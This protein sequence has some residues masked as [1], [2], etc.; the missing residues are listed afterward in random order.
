MDASE[1]TT[2][3]R[4]IASYYDLIVEGPT[5]PAGP[6]GGYTGPTGQKGDQGYPFNV[7]GQGP[8]GTGQSGPVYTRDY[9]DAQPSGFAFLDTTNGVLYVKNTNT[10]GDWSTGIPFGQ[11]ETGPTGRAG[12][13]GAGIAGPTGPTGYVGVDGQT[14]PTGRTGPTGVTGPTGR[15]GVLGPTGPLGT[16]PTGPT[17]PGATGVTGSTGP[18]GQRGFTG[19]TG[20]GSTGPTGPMPNSPPSYNFARLANNAIVT[21]TSPAT[22][23]TLI[24]FTLPSAGTWDVLY[25][26]RAQGASP[27]AG[28]VGLWDSAGNQLLDS[29]ILAS[30]LTSSDGSGAGTGTGRYFITTTDAATYTMRAWASTGSFTVYGTADGNGASSVSWVQLTGGYVG[31][32]GAAGNTGPTGA[33]GTAGAAGTTGATGP[34]GPTGATGSSGSTGSTGTTGSTGSTG[35]TGQT[36][37]TGTTG[38]T[39][40]GNV[41]ASYMRGSRAAGQS[42]SSSPT[43]IIFTQTD[44][45]SGSDISLNQ[46]TGQITL[47]A[48]KT[49]RLIASVPNFVSSGA[50]PR[51][52]FGWYNEISSTQIGS[53][54]TFYSATD[55]A[56]N[57]GSGT[58]AEHI[59][60]PNV[61]TVVSFRYLAGTNISQL[62]GN[63]DF[64]TANSYPWFEIITIA[65]YSPVSAAPVAPMSYVQTTPAQVVI[66]NGTATPATITSITIT[67][68]GNPVQVTFVSDANFTVGSAWARV[69]LY[70][71]STAIGQI[72]Q[73]EPG[74]ENN[75]N[76]PT[77][78]TYIDS[79][80]AGTYTYYCKIVGVGYN[81]SNINFGEASGPTM[82]A[83]ELAGPL[84]PT[85]V[86][87]PT[88]AL[89][90]TGYTGPTGPTGV[91]GPTG[92]T[93]R[94]GPTGP[95]G[96]TGP[97]GA[98]ANLQASS[99]VTQGYLAANQTIPANTDSVI[100]FT[101]D[102]DP[103]GWLK[104]A[105]TSTARFL[106]SIAG[107]YD[108]SYQVTW[109]PG[110]TSGQDNIQIRKNN[111]SFFIVQS[112]IQNTSTNTFQCGSKLVN[113]NGT[114]DYV[115][116]TAFSANVG[117]QA[118][119]SFGNNGT[120]FSARLVSYGQGYTGPT[121]PASLPAWTSAGALI[122]GATTTAPV[123]GT[124]T[125]DNISYRQ[126]GAKE[127]EV[128]ISYFQTGAGTTGSGDYLITLPNSLQFNTTLPMQQVYTGN[129]GAS[130][131]VLSSYAVSDANGV[132]NNTGVGG[133]V[134]PLIYNSTQFRILTVSYTSAVQCWGSAYYSISGTVRVVMTFRFTSL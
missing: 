64:Q 78:L 31:A 119:Q 18:T 12:P 121:G 91:T 107:Y 14:G 76:S 8:T 77:T 66:A 125:T 100:Q 58:L 80:P 112:P 69:Q 27:F 26:M 93:G 65:G 33:A 108:I 84:G 5:G 114:T 111:T 56:S 41:L 102:I 35:P 15:P 122:L 9:Y 68:T 132:I 38:P 83:I 115:D 55:N 34:S 10:S 49:Y 44:A 120:W 48:N 101:P 123:K 116:F 29:E 81:G 42:V 75:L 52:S 110:L 59:F 85:G 124:T 90:P 128:S 73:A 92:P 118:I 79:Q 20:F 22:A 36:G 7:R 6:A 47:Q 11:G 30:Y 98:S 130:T 17:G 82:Y 21:Q 54:Q 61:Q 62:G 127:W 131:W 1:L 133:H 89:G 45:S 74:S 134:F 129:I 126:V 63:S 53:L 87:G 3:R 106:P 109:P 37:S 16:G 96:N 113:L 88:G 24:T 25:S 94:T 40:P 28:E 86:T 95:T 19:P 39:G 70:R 13:T 46:G 50:N 97:T 32:T 60:T 57:G 23:Q 72:V 105:S 117:G 4:I 103:Q 71:D 2:M 43:T 104:N 51:P 67:T 99:Y